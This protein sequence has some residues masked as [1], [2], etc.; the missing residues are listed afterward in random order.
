MKNLELEREEFRLY[1][2]ESGDTEMTFNDWLN[3]NN[4]REEAENRWHYLH[5]NDE[6]DLY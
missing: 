2:A 1:K 6:L 4:R 5:E 3:G